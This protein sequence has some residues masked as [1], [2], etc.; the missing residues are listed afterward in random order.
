MTWGDA[1]RRVAES[2]SLITGESRHH[3]YDELILA[4][5]IRPVLSAIKGQE[6]AGVFQERTVPDAIRLR[7]FLESHSVHH[8]VVLG[9]GFIGLEMAEAFGKRG[10]TVSLVDKAPQILPPVDS[11]L[12]QYF[13]ARIQEQGI[14]IWLRDTIREIGL[15]KVYLE[16]G[17]ELAADAVVL[18]LG[19]RPDLKLARDM[20][21][22]LGTTGAV[23]V[24][25][26]MRTSKPHIFAAG[27]AVEKRDLVTGQRA[28]WPLAGVAN[29][30]GRIAGTNAVG[31]TAVLKG[32]LGTAIV[33]V[34][35]YTVAVTGLTEKTTQARGIPYQVL[36]TIKGDHASY[37]PGS[38]DLFAK[39]LFD[40]EE[41]RLLGAQIAGQNGVD[42]R[43]D[44]FSTAMSAHMTVEQ[45]GELDLAHAPPFG[46]SKDSLTITGMA[47]ENLRHGLFQGITSQV[48]NQWLQESGQDPILLDVRNPDEVQAT[49]GLGDFILMPLDQLRH[50]LDQVSSAKERS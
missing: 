42:K 36:Y 3:S 44:V 24:D 7:E 8:A 34:E 9:S 38:K 23:W 13:A 43:I 48:L 50:N 28:W 19:V 45:L 10:I 41:G 5:G 29:K 21:L 47:A 6:T 26:A 12:A 25:P 18:A 16:S 37:Y 32:A 27:D 15:G 1:E 35:P 33:R 39:I 20:G 49:G 30:E 14:D 4:P 22:K 2:I 40:P 17:S 11:E 46:S 31:G